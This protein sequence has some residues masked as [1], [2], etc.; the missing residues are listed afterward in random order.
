M[1]IQRKL[2]AIYTYD[3]H[4]QIEPFH[5]KLEIYKHSDIFEGVVFRLERYGLT[6]TFPQDQNGESINNIDDALLY[7]K[8][9]FIDNT[10]LVGDSEDVVV[11][12]FIE[13]LNEIFMLN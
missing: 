10:H 11:H 4:G 2:V 3:I 9:E 5:F 7:V 12:V 1:I 6:P 8:D 13:K